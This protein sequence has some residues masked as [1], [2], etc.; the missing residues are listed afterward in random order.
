MIQLIKNLSPLI[1]CKIDSVRWCPLTAYQVCKNLRIASLVCLDISDDKLVENKIK[2][3]FKNKLT[4]ET[5]SIY[6]KVLDLDDSILDTSYI[7]QVQD[8]I[9]EGTNLSMKDALF[10]CA[11]S[12]A[13]NDSAILDCLNDV[14][15]LGKQD[16]YKYILFVI[17]DSY[18]LR[19]SLYNYYIAGYELE[20]GEL[21]Q[22]RL[23]R[24]IN[25]VNYIKKKLEEYN[26]D[27]TT[28]LNHH[29]ATLLYNLCLIRKEVKT[30]YIEVGSL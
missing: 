18:S 3:I 19:Y 20:Y 16:I 8:K 9:D 26:S 6:K 14:K 7:M 5:Y 30:E 1:G 21:R 27:L 24:I 17:L 12:S 25:N 4:I 23:D 15:E 10:F 22:E 11:T 2:Y 29:L 13:K 28:D